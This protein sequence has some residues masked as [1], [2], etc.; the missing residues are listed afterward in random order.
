[1]H[2]QAASAMPRCFCWLS[3][4]PLAL[5]TIEPID[6]PRT[7]P[8]WGMQNRNLSS[9]RA[10]RVRFGDACSFQWLLDVRHDLVVGG[11]RKV[12]F[13]LVNF[14]GDLRL[15]VALVGDGSVSR[16]RLGSPAA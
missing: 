11:L 2:S 6:N 14:L 7:Y 4:G 15:L 5:L 1:M 3:S 9:T 13:L 16:P 8:D 12:A 10:P